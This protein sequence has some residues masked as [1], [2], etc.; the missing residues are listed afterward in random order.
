MLMLK[1]FLSSTRE[2]VSTLNNERLD[3]TLGGIVR[4]ETCNG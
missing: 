1:N 3:S 4:T 2:M